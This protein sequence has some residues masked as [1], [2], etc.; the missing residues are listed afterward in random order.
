MKR[1]SQD[2]WKS[3]CSGCGGGCHGGLGH[4]GIDLTHW[5]YVVALAGNPNT[6]KSTVFNAL[7]GLR[8]HTGNWPGKTVTRAEGG[9]QYEHKRYKLIDLPGTYSLFSMSADEEIARDFILFGRPDCTLITVDATCLERNLNLVLQI[10][11]MTGNAVIALNLMDE[12]KRKNMDIDCRRLAQEL[13]VPVV[14]TVAR[15]GEGIRELIK[16]VANIVTGAVKTQPRTIERSTALK[17]AI[18]ELEP[19]IERMC[20]GLPNAD[21]IAMRL[22]EGDPGIRE[23]LLSGRLTSLGERKVSLQAGLKKRRETVSTP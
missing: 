10:L 7:T 17:Q 4:L 5:D 12:A 2:W 18:G 23:A 3:S 6:G 16:E 11:E 13:G 22:I 21:W 15:T 8:Q 20:P 19:F 14:A 1:I 9:F